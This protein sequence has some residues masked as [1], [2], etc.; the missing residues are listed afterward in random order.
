M[1]SVKKLFASPACLQLRNMVDPHI[2]LPPCFGMFALIYSRLTHGSA[3]PRMARKTTRTWHEKDGR[4]RRE[5]WR[6]GMRDQASRESIR[7]PRFGSHSS[8]SDRNDITA[9]HGYRRRQGRSQTGLHD[10]DDERSFAV[11][12]FVC[13]WLGLRGEGEVG[14]R[15]VDG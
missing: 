8:M 4:S 11:L 12:H 14:E 2:F 10:D 9:R 13:V 5:T 15:R 7:T 3:V 6:A 1:S